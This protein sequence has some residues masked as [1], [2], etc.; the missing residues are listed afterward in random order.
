M[1]TRLAQRLAEC[2]L[3]T[4][5]RKWSIT[6]QAHERHDQGH[7]KGIPGIFRGDIL[8]DHFLAITDDG[9]PRGRLVSI[10]LAHHAQ[11][12]V[13]GNWFEIHR[14]HWA[15]EEMLDALGHGVVDSVRGDVLGYYLWS[16]AACA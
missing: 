8:G 3:G 1:R 5:I 12:A 16:A 6:Q 14:D 4:V 9:A 7:L 15:H 11:D 10:P 13:G 2:L